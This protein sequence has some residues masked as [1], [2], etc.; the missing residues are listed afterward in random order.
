MFLP[1]KQENTSEYVELNF[2]NLENNT[3]KIFL[4]IGTT[5][6]TENR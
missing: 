5:A 6:N 2:N 3:D 4:L 1:S